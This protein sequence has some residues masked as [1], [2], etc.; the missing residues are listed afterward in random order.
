[1]KNFIAALFLSTSIF[2]AFS[3]H[4]IDATIEEG[5][6]KN[7]TSQTID[8][9]I[10]VIH[11]EVNWD[12]IVGSE[13]V[14]TRSGRYVSQNINGQSV[15]V[16]VNDGGANYIVLGVQGRKYILDDIVEA[17]VKADYE[18]RTGGSTI[19]SNYSTSTGNMYD[20]NG[21]LSASAGINVN[22]DKSLVLGASVER[23]LVSGETFIKVKIGGRF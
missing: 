13:T 8:I 10:P 19:Y 2:T 20:P 21:G 11:G 12:A 23:N 18:I 14:S 4:A 17:V 15:G 22:I 5:F 3:A 9:A 6:N 16:A 7:N 1:M